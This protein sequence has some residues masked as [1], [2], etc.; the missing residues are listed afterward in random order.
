MHNR[1]PYSTI[2][3]ELSAALHCIR[4]EKMALA[5]NIFIVFLAVTAAALTEAIDAANHEVQQ[6]K[7]LNTCFYK[8]IKRL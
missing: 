6:S 7:R 8:Y 2:G 5:K 3:K 4:K 1:A